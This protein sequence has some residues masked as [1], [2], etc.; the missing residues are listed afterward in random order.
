MRKRPRLPGPAFRETPGA[1]IAR[2]PFPRFAGNRIPAVLRNRN[3]LLRYPEGS[4]A[5]VARSGCRTALGNTLYFNALSTED[6]RH[7][8]PSQRRCLAMPEPRFGQFSFRRC[9]GPG[10]RGRGNAANRG[11]GRAPFPCKHGVGFRD[12]KETGAGETSVPPSRRSGSLP[13]RES[14]GRT[15]RGLAANPDPAISRSVRPAV[16]RSIVPVERRTG[17]AAVQECGE[18]T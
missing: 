4:P 15:E 13:E 7:R 3:P 12:C 17:I 1:E 8:V 14:E 5:R 9:D 18:T 6:L 10:V 11:I 2:I 16:L